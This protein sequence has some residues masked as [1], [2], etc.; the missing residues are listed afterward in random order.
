MGNGAAEEKSRVGLTSSTR[1]SRP[2]YDNKVT[3][4]SREPRRAWGETSPSNL[5]DDY[6]QTPSLKSVHIPTYYVESTYVQVK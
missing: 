3:S 5:N 6:L 1:S 2:S 4:L